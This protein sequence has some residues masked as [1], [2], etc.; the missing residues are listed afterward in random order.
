MGTDGV[1]QYSRL[2]AILN[3]SRERVGFL[4]GHEPFLGKLG[5]LEIQNQGYFQPGD[6]QIS[7]HLSLVALAE[8]GDD[9]GIHN[10]PVIHDQIR[11]KLTYKMPAVMN[12]IFSLLF[13]HVAAIGQF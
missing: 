3:L 9:L 10:E 7:R 1:T 6:V 4:S 11:N 5:I 2:H 12:R 8:S 13:H